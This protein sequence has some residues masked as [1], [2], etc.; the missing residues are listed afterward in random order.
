MVLREWSKQREKRILT[1]IIKSLKS[2][3]Q[4]RTIFFL[5]QSGHLVYVYVGIAEAMDIGINPPIDQN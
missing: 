1:N 2:P 5:I 4:G 3:H